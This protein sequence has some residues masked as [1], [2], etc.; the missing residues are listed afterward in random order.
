[1]SIIYDALKRLEDKSKKHAGL[2]A[3]R[4]EGGKSK[5]SKVVFAVLFLIALSSVSLLVIKIYKMPARHTPL[6]S[7]T[8]RIPNEKISSPRK[9]ASGLSLNGIFF[10]DGEYLA[11]INDRMVKVGDYIGKA[12]VVKIEPDGVEVKF[13]DSTLRLSYP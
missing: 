3:D 12:Q 7:E 1:M 11:L 9:E 4:P 13:K 5:L 2:E 6:A 10:S 8:L